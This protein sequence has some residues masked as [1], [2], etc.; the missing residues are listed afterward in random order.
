MQNWTPLRCV[1]WLTERE[2]VRSCTS[3]KNSSEL[4]TA[5]KELLCLRKISCVWSYFYN[6]TDSYWM[7]LVKVCLSLNH[8]TLNISTAKKTGEMMW[9][10]LLFLKRAANARWMR[11]VVGVFD[12]M[13]AEKGRT[14]GLASVAMTAGERAPAS[15]R[16]TEEASAA[17]GKDAVSACE[18]GFS[19]VILMP[20]SR[21]QGNRQ[22]SSFNTSPSSVICD[23]VGG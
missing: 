11:A 13:M 6:C 10:H 2:F 12:A 22:F 17:W 5:E 18:K 15:P 9:A 4:E 3:R 16:H 23:A 8:L 14:E 21:P 7:C 20:L 1:V 19:A